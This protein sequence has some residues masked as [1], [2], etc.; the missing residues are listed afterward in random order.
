MSL[1]IPA[2]ESAHGFKV[3]EYRVSH[4]QLL[5]RR[6]KTSELSKN[7][8]IMFYNVDYM[9]LPYAF[10]TLVVREP[11]AQD[12]AFAMDRTGKDLEKKR[13][14]VL[15]NGERRHIVVAGKAVTTES[16]MGL[17]ESPFALPQVGRQSRK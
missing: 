17:F 12:M 4:G 10:S 1:Q 2:G 11:N 6:P 14:F 7:F 5:I 15:Q 13:V 3:W 9:D 16:T 8:D